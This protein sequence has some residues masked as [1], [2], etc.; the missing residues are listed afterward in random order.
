MSG[1]GRETLPEVPEGWEALL[2]VRQLL[3]RPRMSR[4]PSRLSGIPYRMFGSGWLALPNVR[5]W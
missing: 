1:S 2:D 3:G 4:R 5:E